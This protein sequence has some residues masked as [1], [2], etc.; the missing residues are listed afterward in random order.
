VPKRRISKKELKQDE[1]VDF[2]TRT[3]NVVGG[4]VAGH[5]RALI[6]GLTA[7]ATVI[8]GSVGMTQF[9]ERRAVR[10]QEA[11]D[12]VQR[13]A[14]VDVTPPTPGVTP[15]ATDDGLPHLAT[16]KE[17]L[18]AA[19][20]ELDAAFGPSSRGP[21]HA[22]AMLVRGSLLLSLDRAGEAITTYQA[23][24]AD[25]LDKRLRFLAEE[26]L[27]YG[28]EH[29]GKLA[30]A[31]GAFAKLGDDAGGMD[32]FYKDR[33]LFH[34][35]RIAELKSNPADAKRIYHEVL[36]KNPTTSLR[37]EITNRLAALELK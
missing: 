21:L 3:S 36:D 4:Y 27:G 8:A 16:Q 10:A 29:E 20:K 2:W 12:R 37:E 7:L 19:L 28:Y 18:E 23:L 34:Q 1:F 35:A 9:S 24:L 14:A 6:I 15:P 33:A 11:L 25:T 26:G 5:S 31:Q 30:E 17:Q 32:G 22:E 13:I